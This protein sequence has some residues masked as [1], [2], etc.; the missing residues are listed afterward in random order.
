MY[1]EVYKPGDP[2][3]DILFNWLPLLG[4]VAL[5]CFGLFIVLKGYRQYVNSVFLKEGGRPGRARVIEKWIKK[6]HVSSEDRHRRQ[7]MKHYFL[8][9][10]LVDDTRAFSVKQ[11]APIDLWKEVEPGDTVDVIVHPRR[12]L[13]R[14][15][16]WKNY[17]GTNGGAMQ[18]AIGAV[19]AASAIG[20]IGAGALD[21]LQGPEPRVAG[22]EWLRDR[23]EVLS[24]GIPADPFLRIFAP[25]TR[26]VNVVFGDTKG[27]A[28]MGNMRM[29]R[30][31]G[32]RISA[33]EVVDGAI[34][35]AWIDPTNE[36]N[37]VL[38]LER[39]DLLRY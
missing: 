1:Q 38:D 15:A 24:V 33:F 18:M 37:A 13:M 35:G 6:G 5:A 10:E 20:T 3:A 14:L 39:P 27:G 29:V 11:V 28:L 12:N 17:I 31:S 23:A 32:E 19:L 16:A 34:L 7:P 30:I 26:M 4:A 2:V 36:Y 25:G 21:A 9:Y 22:A 8:R